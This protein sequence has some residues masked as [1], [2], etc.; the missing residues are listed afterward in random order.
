MPELRAWSR[1]LAHHDRLW[2]TV[3]LALAVLY[4]P[5]HAHEWI[6]LV[7]V[8]AFLAWSD[9]L[10][11]FWRHDLV[12]CERCRSRLPAAP[13]AAAA[14]HLRSFRFFHAVRPRRA[15]KLISLA[16]SLAAAMGV[17]V[18]LIFA[19]VLETGLYLVD[20]VHHR[21]ELWCPY[22]FDD[23]GGGEDPVEPV[24]PPVPATSGS[25]S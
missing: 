24:V 13:E 12:F 20:R 25:R 9:V 19:W 17:S 5:L 14:R 16:L 18:A 1:W 7:I 10:E 6:F 22:C 4:M 8:V 15:L 21:F 3:G 11:E 2:I 23:N